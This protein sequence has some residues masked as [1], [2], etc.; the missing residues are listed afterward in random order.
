MSF[1]SRLVEIA[2]KLTPDIIVI[3]IA[4]TVLKG[5]AA[6]SD[7]KF[8]LETRRAYVKA[9]LAGEQEPIEVWLENFAITA[10][11]GGYYLHVDR[12]EANRLWLNNLFARVLERPLKIPDSPELHANLKLAAEL[13]KPQPPDA[14]G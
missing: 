5:V 10:D 4:N 14:A 1:K 2:I 8:D 9:T 13:L 12:A 11:E 3:W 7:F 6:L